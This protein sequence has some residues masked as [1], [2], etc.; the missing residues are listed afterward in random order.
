M[1]NKKDLGPLNRFW[2]F[3][4]FDVWLKFCICQS[5]F[6]I[7]CLRTLNPVLACH[8]KFWRWF[9]QGFLVPKSEIQSHSN[10]IFDSRIPRKDCLLSVFV[11]KL[12]QKDFCRRLRS[13][14]KIWF[15]NTKSAQIESEVFSRDFWKSHHR[16]IRKIILE[17]IKISE[18]ENTRN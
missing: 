18:T 2:P 15:G 10:R 16:S 4:A 6:S 7:L 8:R 5:K 9:L 14:C 3:W 11:Q 17:K 12:V 1:F 13:K